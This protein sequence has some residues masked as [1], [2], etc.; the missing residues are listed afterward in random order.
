MASPTARL[1]ELGLELPEPAKPSFNYDAVVLH[2]DLAFVS[3]QM[4]KEDGIVEITGRVGED[5]D[6]DTA[7]RAAEVCALQG[8]AVTAAALGS[9]D[10]VRRIVR[11]TGYVASGTDFHGQPTVLDAASDLLVAIF[12][13]AGR[14]ARSAVGVA[15]LPR[16]APIEVELI[17]AHDLKG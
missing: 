12:G 14:H 4:P 7:R 13:D 10:H 11:V 9:I 15:E 8:L 6:V 1:K 16:D 2:G 5:V 17:V 3:G